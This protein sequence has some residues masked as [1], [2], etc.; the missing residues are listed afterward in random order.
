[1]MLIIRL[2]W[3]FSV[4]NNTYKSRYVCLCLCVVYT[5][6][7]QRTASLC[8]PL[9]SFHFLRRDLSLA[10]NFTLLV[11][12]AGQRAPGICLSP[13]P[14]SPSLGLQGDSLSFLYILG[15]CL[16]SSRSWGSAFTNC[17]IFQAL[18]LFI[19][20]TIWL[21]RPD[22]PWTHDSPASSS[23]SWTCKNASPALWPLWQKQDD[24]RNIILQK[25]SQHDAHVVPPLWL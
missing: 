17:T 25:V 13:P 7:G 2:K 1:M 12:L 18:G 5:S 6:G 20:D 9:G 8:H 21:C 3:E 19:W 22:W 16:R 15:L 4:C 23:E 11:R 24:K 10:L 14:I